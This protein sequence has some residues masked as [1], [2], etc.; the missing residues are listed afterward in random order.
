MNS[1]GLASA[2]CRVLRRFPFPTTAPTLRRRRLSVRATDASDRRL[3][4]SHLVVSGVPRAAERPLCSRDGLEAPDTGHC[5]GPRRT[6]RG[7]Q[8]RT[9]F[10]SDA[11]SNSFGGR[12]WERD[13][14]N[15]F[16]RPLQIPLSRT[17]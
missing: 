17:S 1:L 10:L 3:L 16:W 12:F 7:A 11:A 13:L 5:I 2:R 6:K 8:L 9:I 15:R 4:A 14:A